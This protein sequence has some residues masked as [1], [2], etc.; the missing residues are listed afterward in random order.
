MCM[1]G[2]SSRSAYI[3]S[4][5]GAASITRVLPH[6]MA[7]RVELSGRRAKAARAA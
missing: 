4:S 7:K 2:G 3:G 5:N 1:V 6:P